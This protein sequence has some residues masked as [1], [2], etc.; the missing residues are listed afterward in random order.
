MIVAT[1]RSVAT[2]ASAAVEQRLAELA[3]VSDL[4]E[5]GGLDRT[6]IAALM[7]EVLG[8]P[9]DDRIA[10][11]VERATFGNALF[12]DGVVRAALR[13]GSFRAGSLH[14]PRDVRHAILARVHAAGPDVMPALQAAALLTRP[15][16]VALLT[17]ILADTQPDA[18]ADHLAVA[19]PAPVR[20]TALADVLARAVDE[21]LV[22][23]TGSGQFTFR[24][25]LVAESLAAALPAAAHGA[26]HG[27]I[28]DIITRREG[29]T[30]ALAEIAHHRVLAVSRAGEGLDRAV[31][32]CQRAAQQASSLQAHE[33]AAR[34]ERAAIDLLDAHA[35]GAAARRLE[36]L[37]GLG[38]HLLLAGRRG[39][40]R[41]ELLAAA[42]LAR[43]I[44]ESLGFARAAFGVAETGEFGAWDQDKLGLLEAALAMAEAQDDHLQPEA[45]SLRIRLL[46]RL[47]AE[48]WVDPNSRERRQSLAGTALALARRQG[49]PGLLALALD[50]RFQSLWG[51]PTSM[52]AAPSPTSCRRWRNRSPIP[53]R[54]WPR[55]AGGCWSRWKPGTWSPTTRRS[56][57][58]PGSPRP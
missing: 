34:L 54:R 42:A 49:D 3:R 15:F 44:G 4:I 24:H 53:T 31:S 12:V 20:A 11:A 9:I 17:E 7:T 13:D 14:F 55:T 21:G 33:E 35:P 40:A 51:P 29:P 45:I 6:A 2:G 38:A 18:A 27:R 26:I 28:A 10:E 50:A 48:L 47:A 32:A 5:L 25:G 41:V 1:E 52:N 56:K 37:L 46:A 30:A 22:I 16:S 8:Q 23:P 43:A 19:P 39:D 57:P 58:W 36:L